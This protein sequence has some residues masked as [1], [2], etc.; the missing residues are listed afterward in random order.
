MGSTDTQAVIAR[1]FSAAAAKD[2]TIQIAR[3]PCPQ[4]EL[5]D[6]R[7]NTWTSLAAM[8]SP[9]HGIGAAA[10][11]PRIYV[12]GGASVQGFGAVSTNDAFLV[13]TGKSC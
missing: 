9:R 11:G 3:L 2:I 7:S 10:I 4:T 5:Y 13:P 6:P 12:P 8:L 1:H